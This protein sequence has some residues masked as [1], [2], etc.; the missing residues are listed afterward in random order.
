MGLG[1]GEKGDDKGWREEGRGKIMNIWCLR[2][3]IILV[4]FFV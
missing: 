2:E 3:I 4:W 1:Y